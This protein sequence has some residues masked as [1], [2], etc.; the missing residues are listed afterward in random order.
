MFSDGVSTVWSKIASETLETVS[1]GKRRL[2]LVEPYLRVLGI[3]PP[4]YP[5]TVAPAHFPEISGLSTST[6]WD[7]IRAGRLKTVDSGRRKMIVV[8]SYRA[9]IRELKA[10]PQQDARRNNTVPALGSGRR[11]GRPRKPAPAPAIPTQ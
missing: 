4:E 1:L 3:N 5:V 9:L 10:Q 6:T 7:L 11:H 8:D 2:I